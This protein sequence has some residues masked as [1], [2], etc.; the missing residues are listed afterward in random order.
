LAVRHPAIAD[1]GSVFIL[2]DV[3]E[4]K[5]LEEAQEKLSREQALAEMSA[6]LAHEVRNP[7]GSLE[8]FAGLLAESQLPAECQDW[9]EQVQAG[10]RALAATVNNILHFHSQPEP[11]R[12]SL[13]LGELLAWS[14]DFF[15]PVARQSR[16]ALSL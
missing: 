5:G 13:D 2:R 7:L 15:L 16:V 11:E 4:R 14:R 9:V 1:A 3:S 6:V 10:L 8:L 12:A